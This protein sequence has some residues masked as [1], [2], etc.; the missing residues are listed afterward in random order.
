MERSALSKLSDLGDQ[1]KQAYR[2]GCIQK[3]MFDFLCELEARLYAT[4]QDL[5]LAKG[6][7]KAQDERI[8]SLETRYS[9]VLYA[10]SDRRRG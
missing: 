5:Q 2:A 6:R 3:D 9:Q 10:L 7:L 8:Q 4:E 1:I